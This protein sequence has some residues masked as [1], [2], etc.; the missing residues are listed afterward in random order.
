M[1]H[2]WPSRGTRR[3]RLLPEL[4]LLCL[5]DTSHFFC[6]NSKRRRYGRVAVP[7]VHDTATADDIGCD[8]GA[9]STFERK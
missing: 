6:S 8:S 2:A 7:G 5:G 4:R 3:P 1:S 9:P